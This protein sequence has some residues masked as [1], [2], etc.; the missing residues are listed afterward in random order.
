MINLIALVP[1]CATIFGGVFL[2]YAFLCYASA[3]TKHD[4]KTPPLILTPHDWH[5]YRLLDSGAGR[6]LE[7]VK[8]YRFI[9]PEPQALWQPHLDPQIWENDIDGEFI[10]GANDGGKWALSKNLPEQWSCQFD[11]IRFFAMPTPFRHFGFFPEQSSHWQWCAEHIKKHRRNANTAP[12]ILNLFGYTGI[13]SLHAA[14]AGA[15]VTHVDASKKAIFQAF[16]NRDHANMHDA[17]IRYITEDARSFCAREARRGRRYHGIILDPPKYGRGTKG[18]VWR[19]EDDIA[20][21]LATL[22]N[23]LA[24]EPLFI[25]LT[26]Y[27]IRASFLALHHL[28]AD[29]CAELGGSVQSGEL[30]IQ[31]HRH[32]ADHERGRRIG[33]AIFARW[34]CD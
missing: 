10:S 13:A 4:D 28:L 15:E 26:S 3:M 22:K 18:E 12:R 20:A 24:D 7:A 34:Q 1:N 9:R 27:A 21:L 17:P 2:C 19:M 23:L 25:V 6:K 32:D 5:D 8:N 16:A 14:R 33:Q 30:A 29:A 31:E 11:N